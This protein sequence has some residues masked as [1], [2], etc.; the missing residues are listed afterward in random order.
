MNRTGLTLTS[1]EAIESDGLGD[2]DLGSLLEL[3]E[4][5]GAIVGVDVDTLAVLALEAVGVLLRSLDGLE[6]VL[7]LDLLSETL[8][9]RVVAA[10]ELRL[11][12]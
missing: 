1:N 3:D 2:D 8:A 12:E 11:C 6:V 5:L 10:E 7:E 4:V 9:L